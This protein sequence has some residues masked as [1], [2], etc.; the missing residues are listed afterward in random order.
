[1]FDVCK[2]RF[3]KT[4]FEKWPL[5]RYIVIDFYRHKKSAIKRNKTNT[6]VCMLDVNLLVYV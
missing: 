2:W 3:L 4:H 6:S 1:M 5:K